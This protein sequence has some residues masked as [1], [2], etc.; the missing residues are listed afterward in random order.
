MDEAVDHGGHS[1]VTEDLVPSAEGLIWSS[2]SRSLETRRHQLEEEIGG[3]VPASKVGAELLLDVIS[4]AYERTS[5]MVTGDLP[6][7]SWTEVLG[8]ERLTPGSVLRDSSGLS[9]FVLLG[10]WGFG[11]FWRSPRRCWAIVGLETSRIGSEKYPLKLWFHRWARQ[12]SN[13]RPRDYESP[14]L[15]AELRALLCSRSVSLV[16]TLDLPS[17]HRRGCE[18]VQPTD[19]TTRMAAASGALYE[20]V[21]IRHLRPRTRLG[22]PVDRITMPW[23]EK[24][25]GI[26]KSLNPWSER[27]RRERT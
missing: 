24:R 1:V 15:T 27:G 20:G 3:L 22:V 14:A 25:Q 12:G 18:H 7:E 9:G 17:S 13:L 5:L 8:S 26:A 19:R 10:L 2:R 4:T 21:S 6:F 23:H 11:G 16:L